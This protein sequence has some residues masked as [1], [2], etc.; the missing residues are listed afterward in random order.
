MTRNERAAQKL[1]DY[2]ATNPVTIHP[3]IVEALR[4][5]C[6]KPDATLAE[7]TPKTNETEPKP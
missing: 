6:G 1:L 4:I 5:L 3:F 7:L 2:V